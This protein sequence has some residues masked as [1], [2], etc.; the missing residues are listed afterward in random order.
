MYVYLSNYLSIFLSIYLGK[1]VGLIKKQYGDGPVGVQAKALVT[2]WKE[3]VRVEEEQVSI[4]LVIY[5]SIY[6]SVYRSIYLTNYPSFLFLV[7]KWKR[8]C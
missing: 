6:L 2:K 3:V 4:Y 7:T 8:G 5:L 1:T